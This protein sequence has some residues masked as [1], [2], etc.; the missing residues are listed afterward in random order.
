MFI[1]C[2]S[3]FCLQPQ[4]KIF[5]FPI[6]SKHSGYYLLFWKNQLKYKIYIHFLQRSLQW[7][8]C[9]P[10]LR[11]PAIPHIFLNI[12][13]FHSNNLAYAFLLKYI[14]TSTNKY[15]ISQN[16]HFFNLYILYYV[17]F[18]S[19]LCSVCVL[20]FKKHCFTLLFVKR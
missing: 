16:I 19:I 5:K 3:G 15:V 10:V 7:S 4:K 12:A 13:F 2:D 11:L 18:F 17:H 14:I 20:I 9:Q 8:T 1:Q 6:S